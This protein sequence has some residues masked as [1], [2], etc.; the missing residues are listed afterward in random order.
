[1]ILGYFDESE[2]DGYFLVA[3]FVG[4]RRQWKTLV[5]EWKSVRGDR[6]PLHMKTMRLSSPYAPRRHEAHLRDLGAIPACVGLKPFVGFVRSDDLNALVKGTIAEVVLSGYHV[7]IHALVDAILDS[8][9]PKR[10][11]IE[12]LFEEKSGVE[13]GVAQAFYQ[14]ENSPDFKAH[15]GKSRIAK[16]SFIAKATIMEPSDY[17]AYAC[18]QQLID[19]DSQQARL[20]SPML[21]AY[22]R[23]SSKQLSL[24]QAQFLLS[25]T[26]PG[27]PPLMDRDRKAYLKD[28]LKRDIEEKTGKR[29]HRLTEMHCV[30]R[31][32]FPHPKRFGASRNILVPS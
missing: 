4:N 25:D 19:A 21:K 16:H 17:L 18:L 28:R 8:D 29:F 15:H 30:Y 14:F 24:E 32:R 5:A 31:H 10:D 20:T 22:P 1:M 6:G 27:K 7:A 3:G 9:I 26:L 12:F 13:V 11:R 23:I 2:H